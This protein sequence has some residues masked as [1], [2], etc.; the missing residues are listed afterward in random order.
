M[1]GDVASPSV[2]GARVL[3]A[4]TT[5]AIALA[6][7]AHDPPGRPDVQVGDLVLRPGV[8]THRT[9]Y[10]TTAYVRPPEPLP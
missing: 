7:D 10:A 8:L 5:D 1:T 6:P 2:V 4:V 3:H 9:P